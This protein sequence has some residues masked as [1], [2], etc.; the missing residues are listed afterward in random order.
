MLKGNKHIRNCTPYIL[1]G[2]SVGNQKN[3]L[4]LELDLSIVLCMLANIPEKWERPHICV[5]YAT[6][7]L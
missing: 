6:Q 7:F 5:L 3:C 4:L 1:K 2:N